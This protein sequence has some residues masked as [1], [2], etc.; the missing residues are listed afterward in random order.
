[1]RD[2]QDLLFQRRQAAEPVTL[3][4][5]LDGSVVTVS[6]QPGVG[7]GSRV[8]VMRVQSP[9]LD[10]LNAAYLLPAEARG[11]AE[12][13]AAAALAA[14][15]GA[16]PGRP[17]AGRAGDVVDGRDRAGDGP[18]DGDNPVDGDGEPAGLPTVHYRVTAAE[19]ATVSMLRGVLAALPSS[20]RLV[21]FDADA[22]VALVFRALAA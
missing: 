6:T 9:L 18:V 4:S 1:M 14:A 5:P 10:V 8:V 3:V 12:T 20:A 21:D 22:D 7:T 17:P 19:G 13:L 11:L 15:G 16:A 2:E